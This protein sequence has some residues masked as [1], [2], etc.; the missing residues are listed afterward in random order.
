MNNHIKVSLRV[1]RVLNHERVF[2]PH[3]PL[4]PRVLKLHAFD[5][6]FKIALDS[7]FGFDWLRDGAI[8]DHCSLPFGVISVGDITKEGDDEGFAAVDG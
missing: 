4:N 3:E 2:P 6:L 1:C 7:G 5:G 8:A